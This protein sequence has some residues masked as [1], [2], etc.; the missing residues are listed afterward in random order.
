MSN[1]N[2]YTVTFL[3]LVFILGGVLLPATGLKIFNTESAALVATMTIG[4]IILLIITLY[5]LVNASR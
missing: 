3:F 5:Q 2:I 1:Q 4:L